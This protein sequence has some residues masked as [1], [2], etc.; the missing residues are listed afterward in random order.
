MSDGIEQRDYEC[1]CGDVIEINDGDGVT[2]P[3]LGYHWREQCS[4]PPKP[5]RSR[6]TDSNQEGER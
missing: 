2:V 4:S 3:K 6:D 1:K 5:Y